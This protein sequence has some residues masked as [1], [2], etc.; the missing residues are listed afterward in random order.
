[1]HIAA[2]AVAAAVTAALLSPPAFGASSAVLALS[3]PTTVPAGQ[4][5]EVTLN[6]DNLSSVATGVTQLGFEITY[7]SSKL[8]LNDTASLNSALYDKSETEGS[9]VVTSKESSEAILTKDASIYRFTFRPK[10]GVIDVST[11]IQVKGITAKGY[12]VAT[13]TPGKTSDPDTHSNPASETPTPSEPA[14][15]ATSTAMGSAPGTVAA[16]YPRVTLAGATNAETSLSISGRGLTVKIASVASNTLLQS[17][18]VTGQV[19]S[20]A[21]DPNTQKYRII[22]K[23]SVKSVEINAAP[24][25]DEAK[26]SVS[27]PYNA[28]KVGTNTIIVTVTA[29]SGDKREYTLLITRSGTGSGGA[30]VID[31]QA[32]AEYLAGLQNGASSGLSDNDTVVDGVHVPTVFN[33]PLGL[34]LLLAALLLCG[35]GLATMLIIQKTRRAGKSRPSAAP[36]QRPVPRR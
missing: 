10:D 11:T 27:G 33:Q 28:L 35:V 21:F 36:A 32:L 9:L 12:A 26:V 34:V 13:S 31:S 19:I 4:S 29:P 18:S 23:N 8:T 25:S 2:V 7:D 1:M 20:P 14:N 15:S 3:G 22:V 5:F 24:Q 30:S 6:L 16:A 17:L